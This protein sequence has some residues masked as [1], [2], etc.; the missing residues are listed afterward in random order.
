MGYAYGALIGRELRDQGYNVSLGGGVDLARDPRNGRN[1][2]YQGEDPIL[3]GKMVA[4]FIRASRIRRSSAISSTTRSTTR[5]P[6]ALSSTSRLDQRAMRET[7]LLAFEIGIREGQPG[8][9]MCSYNRVNGD[10]A[11][12]NDYLL[13]QVLKKDWGFK[14]FV[15][16]DWVRHPQHRESGAG[17]PR[18]GGARRRLLRRRR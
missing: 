16:S 17:G 3:A 18:P 10:Y 14:G 11:C 6:A 4:Q 13:N 5:K 2:E 8:M 7:D 9:V 12:E 1:F 15:L